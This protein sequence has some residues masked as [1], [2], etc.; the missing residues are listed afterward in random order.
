MASCTYEISTLRRRPMQGNDAAIGPGP[1][2]RRRSRWSV[3]PL[4]VVAASLAA[5]VPCLLAYPSDTDGAW[6]FGPRGGH[7]ITA[8]FALWALNGLAVLTALIQLAFRVKPVKNLL[9]G[10]ALAVVC[11]VAGVFVIEPLDQLL[12][13]P[14]VPRESGPAAAET[15]VS[16][17]SV[18]HRPDCFAW[19]ADGAYLAA[20]AWGWGPVEE[21]SV[22][23]EVTVVEVG[24]ASVAG[25]FKVSAAVNAM[26]FSPDGKWLAVGTGTNNYTGGAACELAV[27]D[28]PALTRKFTAKPSDAR[29]SFI[30]VA[31][32]A[33]A[34]ALCTIE[35]T[36]RDTDKC[37]VRRWAMPAFTEQLAIRTP[38]SS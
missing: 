35:G 34:K 8:S 17:V 27:F 38:Q 3:L 30:D 4:C 29:L 24:R 10:I 21:K 31:W 14:R 32:S 15:P 19:S 36:L 13:V 26:A 23:S 25:A 37:L 33:D 9:L 5:M 22:A 18:P 2:E 28:V 11:G 20:A 7:R 12:F 16:K 1:V 6:L